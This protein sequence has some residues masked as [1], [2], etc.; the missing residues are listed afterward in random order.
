MA[1]SSADITDEV[2][3]WT[4]GLGLLSLLPALSSVHQ[5]LVALFF[6]PLDSFATTVASAATVMSK[7]F[8]PVRGDAWEF[9]VAR[10]N[11]LLGGVLWPVRRT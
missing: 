11:V 4:K 1:G 10:A 8:T 5:L 6:T 3:L 9:Q 7:Q 2:G